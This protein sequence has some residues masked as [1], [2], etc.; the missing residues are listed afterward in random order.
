MKSILLKATASILSV[1]VWIGSANG[2]VSALSVLAEGEEG[3]LGASAACAGHTLGSF[4]GLPACVNESGELHVCENNF[5][6]ENFRTGILESVGENGHFST[7][8][9]MSV[10]DM[11]IADKDIYSLKGIEFFTALTV[12]DCQFN[13]LTELDVSRNTALIELFCYSNRLTELDVSR[14]TALKRLYCDFNQLTELDVSHNTALTELSCILNELTEL[15]VSRNSA[16]THLGCDFNQLTELDVS[17]NTALVY[18]NCDSNQL[19]ELDVSH[20]TALTELSCATQKVF[21]E[22]TQNGE[23]W[24]ADLSKLV[25]KENLSNILHVSDGVFDPNTGMVTFDD[26]ISSFT[27]VYD[28]GNE[29]NPMEVI[30]CQPDEYIPGDVNGDHTVTSEDALLVLQTATHK[31]TLTGA[32]FYAA[33]V[34]GDKAIDSSDALLILPYVTQKISSLAPAK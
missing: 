5:P 18:L 23:K 29:D 26:E 8:E 10:T 12:L 28:T 17:H 2:L 33:D 14:N 13:E 9:I 21:R 7:Q 1:A 22:L 31:T 20:N 34:D 32:A 3:T 11:D 27:Y 19:T 30:V 15:N 16:L 4:S 24:F 25:S 6:D